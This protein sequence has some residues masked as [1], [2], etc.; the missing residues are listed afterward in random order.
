MRTKI[1]IIG[2]VLTC[3]AAAVAI[4]ALA[5]TWFGWLG[6]AACALGATVIFGLYVRLIAPWHA[7]W[8]ATDEEVA[9]T[10]P[11]DHIIPIAASTTRAIEIERTPE[12]VWPWLVQIGYGRA[13]WYSYDWIDNDGKP[14]ASRILPDLQDLDVGDRIDMVPGVG[15]KVIE[16]APPRYLL[17]GD[18]ESGTWCMALYDTASGSRLISRWRQAWNP[19]GVASRFFVALAGPGAFIMERRML[20]GIKERAEASAP[21]SPRPRPSRHNLFIPELQET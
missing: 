13:G 19:E 15:P 14:S 9:R 1:T 8:G 10:M 7:R 6:I 18:A 16:L 5:A 3:F 20:L 4:W 12:V 11:G 21:A 17:A 2:I